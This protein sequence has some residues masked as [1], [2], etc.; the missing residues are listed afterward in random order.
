M[1]IF[2]RHDRHAQHGELHINDVLLHG[3]I[4]LLK[5][6]T[7]CRLQVCKFYLQ[8]HCAYGDKCRYDH[9]HPEWNPRT[10]APPDPR[11]G[12]L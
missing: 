7:I 6:E 11:Q 2:T 12:A 1:P 9:I 10:S 5:S 3:A 4:Q 8:G